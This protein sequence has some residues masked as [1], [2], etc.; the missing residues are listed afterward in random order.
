MSAGVTIRKVCH[1]QVT[2]YKLMYIKFNT[3]ILVSIR[4]DVSIITVLMLQAHYHVLAATWTYFATFV[5]L[6]RCATFQPRCR[7]VVVPLPLRSSHVVPRY[8]SVPSR[9][10]HIVPRWRHAMIVVSRS[11]KTQ[12]AQLA[13]LLLMSQSHCHVYAATFRYVV[14]RG[15]PWLQCVHTWNNV[16]ETGKA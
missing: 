3:D 5:R 7:L 11:Y 16:A 12:S 2:K 13:K 15:E 4:F 9:S 14:K 10:S 6:P 8:A 1:D